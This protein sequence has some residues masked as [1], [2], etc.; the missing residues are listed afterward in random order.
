MVE[1]GLR[2]DA[3]PREPRVGGHL[4]QR[5]RTCLRAQAVA[6][7]LGPAGGDADEGGE[8]VVDPADRVQ[9]LGEGVAGDRL[10]HQPG[11][12][13]GEGLPHVARGGERV[14]HVVQAVEERHEVVA[15][16]R[17][18]LGRRGLERHAV[19]D[20]GVGRALAGR[21]DRRVVVVRADERR[22]RVGLRHQHRRRPVAAADVGDARPGL[23][24]RLDAVEGR[25]PLGDEVGVVAGT[26]E[27]LAADEHVVVV[28]V[29]P[30]ARAGAVDLGDARLGPQRPER[31]DERAGQV[32]GPVGV[33]QGEGLL[34]GHGEGP[35]RRLVLDV[36]TRGLP[37]EP[38]ADVARRR[39]GPLG[40]LL[41]GRGPLGERAVEAE[42]VA[43][44]D[45][46]RR[47]RG[48]EVADHLADE[49]HRLVHVHG[50]RSAL[51]LA[52][53]S[54]PGRG[55]DDRGR[56]ALVAPAVR[57]DTRAY[58]R[59]GAAAPIRSTRSARWRQ[60][61]ARAAASR[62][63]SVRRARAGRSR[64]IQARATET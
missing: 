44:D 60:P 40:E 52:R 14:A 9:V 27:R 17:E 32:D 31:E 8:P 33:G 3:E 13:R 47:H 35:G 49:L 58:T 28:L 45:P 55:H 24:L 42:P 37:G 53:G 61:C 48:A 38:L 20:P 50:H 46:A 7:R 2:G 63:A 26:E 54:S 41:C 36:A 34:L 12:V 62:G 51:P 43:H 56:C 21:L 6:A 16:A 30:H 57:D 19:G 29:P 11:A 18:R 10:D 5:G 15:G 4:A 25:D 64:A 23:Q 1:R 39:A 59:A 22:R